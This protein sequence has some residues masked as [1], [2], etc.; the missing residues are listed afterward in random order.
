MTHPSSSAA[1]A[2]I[3]AQ[4]EELAAQ[5]AKCPRAAR[6]QDDVQHALDA[7]PRRP[8]LN[9]QERTLLRTFL[10]G[11]AELLAQ[12][13]AKGKEITEEDERYVRERLE[14]RA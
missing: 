14:G 6:L 11:A 12:D 1:L 9:D 3:V 4:A 8:T 5:R 2:A 7:L 13:L 10:A